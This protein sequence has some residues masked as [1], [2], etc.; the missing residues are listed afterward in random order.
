M[1]KIK[2]YRLDNILAKDAEYNI[3]L[4]Q[5]SNGKSYAVK[6]HCVTESWNDS[7]K[8]FI[9][10]RRLAEEVK[11][12]V[13]EHYFSDVDIGRIS[14]GKCDNIIV[15]RGQVWACRYDYTKEKNEKV[16]VLGY[17]LALVKATQYKSGIYTD[18]SNVIY[19][20]F[21]C[22]VGSA[23]LHDEPNQLQSLISTIAR[24]NRIHVYMVGNTISRVCPYFTEWQLIDIPRQKQGTIDIYEVESNQ[25]DDNNQPL[26]LKIAVENAEQV[27]GAGKMF[28]GSASK[29]IN[30][31][32]WHTSKQYPPL[33]NPRDEYTLI[34]TV[35]MI[36]KGFSFLLELLQLDNQ[37]TWYVS[38]KTT[39]VK[40]NTRVVSDIYSCD[41]LWTTGFNPLTQAENRA[42][43][44]LKQNK[45]AFCDSLTAE[46]FI[47]VKKNLGVY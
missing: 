30:E 22:E 39:K 24:N 35:V 18:C 1:P 43:N 47:A 45:I 15:Y 20:E 33:P 28:F 17:V 32:A 6:E 27:Q 3:I 34:Y 12:S 37:Y 21:I 7:N 2:Y 11:P 26:K 10:L 8:K 16:R 40:P 13:I 23:Y 29:M 9:V 31:G 4:G 46:E 19:E 42:F 5:R 14:N 44:I 41:P 25:L 38:R 36:G